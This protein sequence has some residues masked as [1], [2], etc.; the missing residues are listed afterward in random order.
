MTVAE[1][2]LTHRGQRAVTR[3]DGGSVKPKNWT[4]EEFRLK[5][6]E[7]TQRESDAEPFYYKWICSI[8]GLKKAQDLL[9]LTFL[10]IYFGSFGLLWNWNSLFQAFDIDTYSWPM[11]LAWGAMW[12]TNI[13]FSFVGSVMVHNTMHTPLYRN[14]YANRIIQHL[15]TLTYG[16][17]VSSYV[18]GHNLSHH[19]FTQS[20]KDVMSTHLMQNESNLYN[21]FLFQPTVALNIMQSDF[22]YIVFQ[23][24][25]GNTT[26]VSQSLREVLLF[27]SVQGFLLYSHFGKAVAFFWLPHFFAQYAI[28]TLSMLQHDGCEEFDPTDKHINFN[29]SR[30]FT[31]PFLNFFTLNNGYHTI[32]HLCPTSHWSINKILHDELCAGHIDQR[33][34]NASMLQFVL[35]YYVNNGN[36]WNKNPVRYDYKGI[37]IKYF[38]L[39]FG[40]HVPGAYDNPNKV[41]LHYEEWMK[42]PEG[43]VSDEKIPPTKP[44]L[45]QMIGLLLVKLLVS[46]VYSIDPGLTLI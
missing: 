32:H 40:A 43:Y 19:K 33:L 16:H 4:M 8:T 11:I 7:I 12:Y 30:N 21:L 22:R 41:A 1:S 46:P 35:D 13:Y 10:A 42:F 45:F 37:P 23:K 20:K 28:V 17:P 6:R 9:S 34:N 38:K 5:V 25:Q 36:P 3:S 2:T 14:T 18:P 24:H 27:L 15:L 26:F 31:N 39:D 29:T 44:K